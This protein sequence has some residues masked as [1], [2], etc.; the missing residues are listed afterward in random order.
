[1]RHAPRLRDA[2]EYFTELL[3]AGPS[4]CA[5]RSSPS[6]APRDPATEFY[7]ERFREWHFLTDTAPSWCCDEAG[8]FFLKYRADE[9]AEIIDHPPPHRPSRTGDRPDEPDA[10]LV[11]HAVSHGRDGAH[12]PAEPQPRPARGASSPSAGQL[13]SMIGPRSPSSRSRSGS[14]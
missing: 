5:P 4:G 14:T 3:R 2:E 12:R 11:P 1:M 7:E 10:H 13:V 9:L 8:H 6:S